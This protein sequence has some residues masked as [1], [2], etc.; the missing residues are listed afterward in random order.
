ML[1]DNIRGL[2]TH[3]SSLPVAWCDTAAKRKHRQGLGGC[4]N[5]NVTSAVAAETCALHALV[6]IRMLSS[7]LCSFWRKAVATALS[8]TSIEGCV[9]RLA[10]I[11]QSSVD[12]WAERGST[13]LM[14]E[15]RHG[16]QGQPL[17]AC[18]HQQQLRQMRAGC[19]SQHLR[20]GSRRS[21][22]CRLHASQCVFVATQPTCI[23]MVQHPTAFACIQAC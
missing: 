2:L 20:P 3:S 10:H 17:S 1:A 13:S 22:C 7:N 15:V 21:R 4:Y 9:P 14:H 6:H 23:H 16:L 11:I 19:L 8:P 5:E 18:K 12:S